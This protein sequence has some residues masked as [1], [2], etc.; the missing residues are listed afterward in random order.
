MKNITTDMIH[1]WIDQCD[2]QLKLLQNAKDFIHREYY[3]K[4]SI[5]YSVEE[6][7]QDYFGNLIREHKTKK[8]M[9]EQM[10]I[11]C[12]TE[13]IVELFGYVLEDRVVDKLPEYLRKEFYNFV[14][15]I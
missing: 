12:E 7:L 5:T 9:L 15:E 1:T 8:Q 13:N 11:H 3:Q 6:D 4:D 2:S 10:L 14:Y